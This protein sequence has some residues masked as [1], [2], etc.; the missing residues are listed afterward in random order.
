MIF[1]KL[2]KFED[3][4]VVL[5]ALLI[6]MF[7]LIGFSIG[8]LLNP[9]PVRE[10]NTVCHNV[11]DLNKTLTTIEEKCGSTFITKEYG[12]NGWSV[13]TNKCVTILEYTY[14]KNVYIKVEDC[15]KDE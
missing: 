11:A 12:S 15:L 14:C 7:F 13:F 2:K 9:S 6:I 5:P 4:N 3:W 10:K 1:K 8:G